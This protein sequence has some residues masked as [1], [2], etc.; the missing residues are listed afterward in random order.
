RDAFKP[1][2]TLDLL[3]RGVVDEGDAV[4]EDVAMRRFDEVGLLADAD[5]RLADDLGHA[6]LDLD[7]P[8]PVV[9]SKLFERG[10]LLALRRDVLPVV[11]ADRAGGWRILT[12]RVLGRARLA[13]EARC[14][15]FD[16]PKG[17]GQTVTPVP[18]S[19]G[20]SSCRPMRPES[21]IRVSGW[22]RP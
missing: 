15:V 21:W 16:L 4:G 20:R 6:R 10:P 2:A 5:L 7:E 14:H 9:L 22:P 12:R 11:G 19:I 3:D 1:A 13:D 8:V 17:K 18:V